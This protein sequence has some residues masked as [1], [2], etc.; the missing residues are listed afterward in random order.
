M[1]VCVWGGGSGFKVEPILLDPDFSAITESHYLIIHMEKIR[2]L[3][4][5]PA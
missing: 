1:C 4:F 3:T 2:C 5:V